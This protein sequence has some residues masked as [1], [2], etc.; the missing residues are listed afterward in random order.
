MADQGST[1]TVVEQHRRDTTN[2]VSD[3][4]VEDGLS[5]VSNA[6]MTVLSTIVTRSRTRALTAHDTPETGRH[7]CDNDNTPI[8]LEITDTS[9]QEDKLAES[10]LVADTCIRSPVSKC[11]D[12]HYT[13]PTVLHSPLTPDN[14]STSDDP[15]S[16]L[17]TPSPLTDTESDETADDKLCTPWEPP[18]G[19][20]WDLLDGLS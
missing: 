4:V 11:A 5:D 6:P 8:L 16:D 15:V 2:S 18:P 9:L 7:D 17:D 14:V 19:F 3:Q 13:A 10:S 1:Q 12:E 20:C